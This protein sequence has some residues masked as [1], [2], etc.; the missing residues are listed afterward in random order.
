MD[1]NDLFTIIKES[2][3]EWYNRTFSA[4]SPVSILINY[5]DVQNLSVKA[6]H[7]VT[8]EV[9]AVGTEDDMA[10]ITPILSLSESYNHATIAPETEK[11]KMAKQMLEAFYGYQIP[12]I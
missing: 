1:S 11:I 6:Y 4:G 10:V 5:K 8:L 9:Q 12:N 3:E 7:T 2:F